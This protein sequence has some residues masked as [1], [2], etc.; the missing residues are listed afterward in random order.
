MKDGMS[1]IN[2]HVGVCILCPI[3]VCSCR[4]VGTDGEEER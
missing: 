2:I 3:H 4:Q 1:E